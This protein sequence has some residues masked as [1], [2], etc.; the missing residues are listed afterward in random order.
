M[1]PRILLSYVSIGSGHQ[2]AAK[3]IEK[4]IK[5]LDAEIGT[6]CVNSFSF[7]G[8]IATNIVSFIYF[9]IIKLTPELWGCLYDNIWIKQKI[10]IF[11]SLINWGNSIR[12][13]SL[14]K[15][16]RPSI[17]VCTQAIPCGI[18]ASLKKRKKVDI[19][20]VAVIT[21]FV[22]H[23]YWIYKEVDVYF[24]A[25]EDTKIKLIKHGISEKKIE[26]TG[27]PIDHH[28]IDSINKKG[29]FE[30]EKLSDK[31]KTILLMGGS[32]GFGKLEEMVLNLTEI[33]SSCQIIAIAGNN[34]KLKK[35]LEKIAQKRKKSI[36]V[37]GYS[38]NLNELMEISDLIITKPGGLTSSEVLAKGLPMVIVNPIPGQ[39]EGNSRFLVQNGAAVRV[40]DIK[41][42]SN[43]VDILFDDP[44]KLQK[45]RQS[46]LKLAKP[47]ASR[48]IGNIIMELGGNYGNGSLH[49]K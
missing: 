7:S 47:M 26:V 30:K 32:K 37:Y 13:Y 9:Y 34:M 43:I 42:L 41:E 12:F 28:F 10:D 11:H 29:I 8:F 33:R 27:I 2:Q 36:K 22:A 3:A 31:V 19:P 35:R 1:K 23:I 48:D 24:V 44:A 40:D 20:L 21:D 25:T 17:V 38:D 5:A 45:M 16:F 4:Y 18:V 14:I 39:E 6:L 15:R 46:A 49:T